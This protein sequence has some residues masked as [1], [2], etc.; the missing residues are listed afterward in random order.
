MLCSCGNGWMYMMYVNGLLN[1]CAFPL[2][3]TPSPPGL[4]RRLTFCPSPMHRWSPHASS[5]P[6][7]A[8]TAPQVKRLVAT[9]CSLYTLKPLVAVAGPPGAL[10]ASF[11][12]TNARPTRDVPSAL[13]LDWG[14]G[15]GAPA[16]A[17]VAP[18]KAA[19]APLGGKKAYSAIYSTVY[20]TSG[21]KP[22]AVM[23]TDKT[24]NSSTLCGTVNVRAAF[25]LNRRG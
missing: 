4:A 2:F 15:G 25:V 1:G 14:S 5:W 8:L 17:A 24:G 10:N 9:S 23:V 3:A 11:T 16:C 19:I 20:N 18:G 6:A 12:V 22:V 7:T 21:A 13:S